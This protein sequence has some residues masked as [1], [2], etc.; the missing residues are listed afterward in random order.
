MLNLAQVEL[1][2]FDCDGV[3]VD[4]EVIAND[5][6]AKHVTRQGWTM[7]SDECQQNFKGR[8]LNSCGRIIEAYL[9]KP[10][11]KGFFDELQVETY[12][13]FDRELCAIDG[14]KRLLAKLLCA[15]CVASSGSYEKLSRTLSKTRLQSVFGQRVYS[16]DD[17]ANGKPAPDI[18]LYAAER[19]GVSAERC[20]V[21]EDAQPGIEAAV[22]AGM[23]VIHFACQ[24]EQYSSLASA[25]VSSMAQLQQQLTR[26]GLASSE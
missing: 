8:S 7:N 22:A 5:V 21:I 11:P 25:G 17:V 15:N 2:I 23:Q 1:I 16:A 6:L 3:L 20:L 13:R 19:M 9:G 14:V 4:S 10:L 24:S 18:F 12:A 26:A